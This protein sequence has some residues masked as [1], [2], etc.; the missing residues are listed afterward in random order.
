VILL[1]G[2]FFIWSVLNGEVNNKYYSQ[3]SK[4]F[5]QEFNEG[6]S[7]LY[8][9]AIIL[10]YND[11]TIAF[12]GDT[13]LFLNKTI[14]FSEIVL[15]TLEQQFNIAKSKYDTIDLKEITFLGSIEPTSTRGMI[16]DEYYSIDVPIL[17]Q[18]ATQNN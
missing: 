1:K 2:V 5:S 16:E 18:G 15:E 17:S 10:T 9:Q 14:E 4:S 6:E 13:Y 8:K 12:D 3:Y 7:Q 11:S